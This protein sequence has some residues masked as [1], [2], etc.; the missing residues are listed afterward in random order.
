MSDDRSCLISISVYNEIVE[1]LEN[2]KNHEERSQP[3]V[4]CLRLRPKKDAF[5]LFGSDELFDVISPTTAASIIRRI[6]T[7]SEPS[8]DTAAD[9]VYTLVSQALES[10]GIG[11]VT[12][13]VM[14]FKW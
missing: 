14:I 4:T 8:N 12:A 9:A 7:R 3:V 6:I 5:L 11:P 10:G 13:A 2:T 1:T